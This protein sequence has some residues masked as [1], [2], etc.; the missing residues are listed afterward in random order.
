MQSA[1]QKNSESA[2]QFFL[3]LNENGDERR[4]HSARV[5]WRLVS[6]LC[7][8]APFI[9]LG[10]GEDSP[11]QYY[12]I[13]VWG[14]D[15]GLT[16]GSVTDVAQTPEG[17]LWVGTLFGS[18][19]RFDGIRFVS[20]NSAN[21][22]E[23][24]LKWGVPRLMVDQGGALWISMHDGG[25]TTWDKQGFRSAFTSIDQPEG[26]LWSAPGR[27]IFFYPSGKLLSG[28]KRAEQWD[29]EAVT[30]EGALRQSQPCADAEG[31]VWYLRGDQEIG[32]WNG[33]ETRILPPSPAL[34]NRPITVLT[35]DAQGRVWVGTDRAV[36]QWQADHFEVMTPT[37]GEALLDVRR[38]VPSGASNLW[39]EANGRMRRCAGRQWVAESEGWNR[40]LGK[41]VSLR[42]LHGD[43]EGGLW[44]A[45]GDLGLIHVLPD[46]TFHRLTTRDG[47]PSN[48]V[49][50]AYQDRDGNTWTGYER[51]GLVR[52]RRRLFQVIGKDQGLSDSLVNTVCEDAQG[53]VWIGLHSGAVGHY[54]K[55]V[56]TNLLL[57]DATNAQDSC[58]TANGQGS[59]WLGAQGAGLLRCEKDSPMQP[60]ATMTQLQSYPRL[61]LPGR[62]DRLW[63][64]TTWS[65]FSL[66]DGVFT[67]NYTAQTV[68][69]HPTALVEATDG[70][71]W[72]GT[73]AGLLLRWD[74]GRFVPLEP[75]DHNS[76]GRIWAL[77]PA[78][79]GGLWAGT[80]VGGLLHW[81]QG[82]FYRYTVK[83]GL[84]SD[85]VVQ[86]LG[87]TGG[88]LWL[89]T[90]AGLVR[91]FG[92]ALARH[93]RGELDELPV[94][95]Y[96]TADGLLTIGS[97]IIFQPNCWHGRDGTLFF[98]M[99][100]SV[101]SVRP[102]EVHINPVPP[103]V[104][105]EELRADDRL[106]LPE[107]V[108]AI[109]TPSPPAADG[110]SHPPAIKIGP[111]RGDLE[112]RYTGLSLGSP[113]RVRFKYKLEGLEKSWNDAGV[114][115]KASYRHVPPGDYVFRVTACNS[116]GVCS[117]GAGLLAVTVEPHFYQTAWFQGAAAVLIAGTFSI[118]VVIT[119]RRRLRRRLEESERQQEL[120]R[121]RARIAQDLH[122]DLGAG[123]TEIGLLGGLLRD[124]SRFAARKQEA[125][126]RIVQRCHDLVMRL[127]EIVWAVNPRNDSVNS[128]GGYLGRYAQSFLEPTSIRCRLEIAEA[129]PDRPLSSEERHNLFLAFEEV[130]ANIV[131]HSGATEVR[132]K[133]SFE[134]QKRLLICIEDNGRGL[135][136][137]VAPGADGLANL[138]RRM[139]QIEGQC[140]ILSGPSGGVA[141]RLSLLLP[142]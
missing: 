41:L 140:E 99:A 31:R 68:G 109:L 128:L 138:H 33:H 37:N 130:L 11:G 62:N 136:S 22:P 15:E 49:R 124:P 29:W 66:K 112:F 110:I 51:G 14:A 86:V 52:V 67:T 75:P 80:E 13:K 84:P 30:P 102:G 121:E 105:L 119:M 50:F 34:E 55:G 60:V 94:S 131:K 57:P 125:L 85:S 104:A 92:A 64:G 21:T 53:S 59:V 38:I 71:I 36:A 134:K 123:L 44:A 10:T 78:P 27:V 139:A 88:N 54:E 89:G 25:L 95:I 4:L 129:E 142:P 77:W 135:P 8:I 120:E 43:P 117:D 127:D 6:L 26:L 7:V 113:L 20:Y 107:R 73:L 1:S 133:M 76:L 69:E 16:E 98:A 72:A 65:I 47:L 39:V 3:R 111:G 79:D 106:V 93:E 17:Y 19:L 126:D 81:T 23:F 141:V 2:R 32:L 42:F 9:A 101:A 87:D 40:E 35:S 56:C 100:N 114:E 83:E 5:L 48:T 61:L 90:R 70:T 82:R 116:D 122:D 74:G 58:A 24:L 108:G 28:R 118:I 96:G 12:T 97:A 132:V 115:R 137:A 63:V 103:S 18:V 91:I 46:G 45:A